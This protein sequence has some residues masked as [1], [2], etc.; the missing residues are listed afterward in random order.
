MPLIILSTLAA[1]FGMNDLADAKASFKEQAIIFK[2]KHNWIMCIIYLGTFGSFLGFAAG[3]ALLTK[4]QFTGI[5]PVKYAFVGPLVSAL[6]RPVGGMWADK[7]QS[8]AKVTQWVFIGMIL[9]VIGVICFLPSGGQGGHFWGFFACFVAL[10]ALTGLGNGS[11]FMQIPVIFLNLHQKLA[12]QGLETAEQ[13]RLSA[14]KEGAAVAGF[15]GAFAAYGGFFIPKSYSLSIELS[16]NV[17]GAFVGFIVFY[18]ICL[19]LNWWY[20]ARKDAEAKC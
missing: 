13:A 8:G 3:F 15:T 20:Y 10:F 4:S 9:S 19:V 14:A 1:W 2:R 11:T 12:E 17:M 5:D 18:T 7:I 6:A 16:G